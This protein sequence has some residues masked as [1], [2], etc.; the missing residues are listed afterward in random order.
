MKPL[1]CPLGFILLSH[2][3]SAVIDFFPSNSQARSA[4]PT[5]PLGPWIVHLKSDCSHEQFEDTIKSYQQ[6]ILPFKVSDAVVTHRYRRLV[7]ALVVNGITREELLELGAH[8]VVPDTKK[9]IT[10]ENHISWGLDRIDQK[11]G[12]L[13]NVYSVHYEGIGVDVYVVDTGIDTNHEEFQIPFNTRQIKNIFNAY[14]A[15]GKDIDEQGHGTHVAG[16][17]GGMSSGAA[18]GVNI[19]GCKVLPASGEGDSSDVLAALEMILHSIE[20]ADHRPSVVSMSL[21]GPCD[22]EDCQQDTIVQAV[23]ELIGH[24]VVVSVA[25]G[26]EAC[27]GCNGSPASARH[28]ISAG[29]FD[30]DDKVAFFSN[31]GQCVTIY[32]PGVKIR[33]ACAYSVCKNNYSF[34]YLSGTSMA[35][36]HVTG[37]IAQLLQKNPSATPEEVKAALTCD[38]ARDML[39][40]DVRDTLSRNLLLQIPGKQKTPFITCDAG[41]GCPEDCSSSGICLNTRHSSEK[42]R[43]CH[44]KAGYYGAS[45]SSVSDPTCA[46]LE[47]TTVTIDMTDA[48]GDGWSFANFAILDSQN[49]VASNAYDGLCFGEHGT[50]RYCLSDGNYTLQVSSGYHPYEVAWS[51]CDMYG[52]SPFTNHFQILNRKCSFYCS[53]GL[54]TKINLYDKTGNGWNKAYYSIYTETG[55]HLY[56]GSLTQGTETSHDLCLPLGCNTLLMVGGGRLAKE[57]TFEICGF[58]GHGAEV[59][60]ICVD[61]MYNCT[62]KTRTPDPLCVDNSIPFSMFDTSDKGWQGANMT[63]HTLTGHFV[64][65]SSLK[66]GFAGET[67]L[68]LADGCYEFSVTGGSDAMNVFWYLCGKKGP[69]PWRATVCMKQYYGLCYG[70]TNCPVLLSHGKTSAHQHYFVSNIDNST[71]LS[72][73]IDAGNLHGANELCDLTDGCYEVVLGTGKAAYSGITNE[74]ELCGHIGS[75][76]AVASICTSRNISTCTVQ[77]METL[78]CSNRSEIMQMIVMVDTFGDGWGETMKYTIKKENSYR[79]VAVGSL[80]DGE[81]GYDQLCLSP[82]CYTISL[83]DSWTASDVVWFFCGLL[84]GAPVDE[85]R[86]CVKADGSCSFTDNNDDEYTS[87]DDDDFPSH[88]SQSPATQATRTPTIQTTTMPTR[89]PSQ[90]PIVPTS[91]PSN[92]PSLRPSQTPVL[93]I[94][95]VV[96]SPLPSTVPSISPTVASPLPVNTLTLA[97][98][99]APSSP[100]SGM[101]I[102]L[103]TSIPSSTPSVTYSRSPSLPPSTVPSLSPT[104]SPSLKP[105]SVM[106]TIPHGGDNKVTMLVVSF[107]MTLRVQTSTGGVSLYERDFLFAADACRHALERTGFKLWSV[108]IRE[109]RNSIENRRILRRYLLQSKL[110]TLSSDI[111]SHV[112]NNIINNKFISNINDLNDKN[113]NK[114]TLIYNHKISNRSLLFGP[115]D[116]FITTYLI[117]IDVILLQHHEKAFTLKEKIDVELMSSHRTGELQQFI[118]KALDAHREEDTGE[119]KKITEVTII[120]MKFY[121]EPHYRDVD[122]KDPRNGGDDWL[123]P[124]IWEVG[125][126]QPLLNPAGIAGIC[127]G[128]LVIC[129][130][131]VY[132]V[133]VKRLGRREIPFT[134]YEGDEEVEI[135]PLPPSKDPSGSMASMSMSTR[136]GGAAVMSASTRGMSASTRGMYAVNPM[137]DPS[138]AQSGAHFTIL[139]ESDDADP[140]LEDPSLTLG[141]PISHDSEDYTG[142]KATMVLKKASKD[143]DEDIG[144]KDKDNSDDDADVPDEVEV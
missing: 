128:V 136:G 118:L 18:Q 51:M 114:K 26:N 129:A 66:D 95:P 141:S 116:E 39:E 122:L 21:G 13:N 109:T 28:A 126:K 137:V 11:E 123:Y 34:R 97:P 102:N 132:C 74:F 131:I 57:A 94:P 59:I 67:D 106:P 101:P 82:G 2:Y 89:L 107:N 105:V 3:V 65:S 25:A 31:F 60:S 112:T 113:N 58:H 103:P 20:A 63:L 139:A 127:I 120:D 50:K 45:C 93:P 8:K 71:G 49:R 138:V 104:S 85:L 38:A 144:G 117:V 79:R 48:Y 29:A 133:Y 77:S 36:P 135:T 54:K 86:F 88:A 98:I 130:L 4:T 125:K 22:N 53:S 111:T 78:V 124:R 24:G 62:V 56:G 43:T 41:S 69:V 37:V 15:V 33:S 90:K 52:G 121:E 73:L 143:K 35:C 6:R 42:T 81:Y 87:T 76:P 17:I 140:T 12:P 70:L 14:G 75:L 108:E 68:C 110:Q 16:I 19:Y 47:S 40:F 61:E 83:P 115:S 30:I 100:P 64:T 92:N 55:K 84:G 91:A 1:L 119:V 7:H 27:N 5:S 96:T 80:E 23:E 10:Q 9:R 44:C 46:N 99:I 72:Q 142:R 134:D 32:A